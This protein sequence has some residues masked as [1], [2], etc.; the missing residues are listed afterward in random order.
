MSS[1]APSLS[2]PELPSTGIVCPRCRR[3]EIVPWRGPFG[4]RYRCSNHPSCM[5][6]LLARPTGRT[7]NA[8][9][10]GRVCGALM[11]QGTRRIGERCSDPTCPDHLP[12]LHPPS[13]R[14]H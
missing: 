12:H 7:C 1:T 4:L 2:F 13:A 10:L 6:R 3:G 14:G 11:M 5:L 9:R 8:R